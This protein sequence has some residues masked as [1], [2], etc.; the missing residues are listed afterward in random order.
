MTNQRTGC[1]NLKLEENVLTDWP[2]DWW[3]YAAKRDD[4]STAEIT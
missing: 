3:I 4:A 2:P 1:M